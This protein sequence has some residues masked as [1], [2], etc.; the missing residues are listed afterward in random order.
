M[1]DKAVML[2]IYGLI[3][4]AAIA[5]RAYEGELDRRRIRDHVERSGGHV[6]SIESAWSFFGR[7]PG[8]ARHYKV[9]Y[10][11]HHG[12]T[13]TATCA[14]NMFSGVWWIEEL[15]PGLSRAE[16]PDS[17]APQLS[18]EEIRQSLATPPEPIA[19]LSCGA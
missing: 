16:D 3:I 11:T 9:C 14:T 4:V 19:C 6:H 1:D 12:R 18:G 10:K 5:L 8:N 15:P 2:L 13:V 17:G 7:R